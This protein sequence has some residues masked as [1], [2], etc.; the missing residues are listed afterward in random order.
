MKIG[1]HSLL[2]ALALTSLRCT[3]FIVEGGKNKAASSGTETIHSSLYGFN[4]AE[5]S[6]VKSSTEGIYRIEASTNGL[7]LFVSAISLGLY[8]PQ[9][10]QWWLQKEQ[11]TGAKEWKP[12]S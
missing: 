6:K 8:V 3:S 2:L 12:G 10:I 4:W 1:I 5:R 11:K 9:D 7:Y